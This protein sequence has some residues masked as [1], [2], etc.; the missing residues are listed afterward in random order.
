MSI[1]QDAFIYGGA[2]HSAW[3]FIIFMYTAQYNLAAIAEEMQSE[4]PYYP[5]SLF[6]RYLIV[7]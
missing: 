7:F 3:T 4:D 5:W 2:L 1:R 6:R